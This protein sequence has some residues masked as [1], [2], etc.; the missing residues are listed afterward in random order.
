MISNPS[1][2]AMDRPKQTIHAA[3]LFHDN[4][5]AIALACT[6]ASPDEVVVAVVNEDMGFAGIWTVP[7][8]ALQEQVPEMGQGGWSMIFSPGTSVEDIE[9]RSL[10]LARLAFA[11][12]EAMRRWVSKHS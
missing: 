4:A 6:D 9:D 10:R 1:G 2:S 12:W 3:E 11:R 8:D 7:L 5:K